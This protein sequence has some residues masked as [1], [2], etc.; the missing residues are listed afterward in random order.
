MF[1]RYTAQQIVAAE[2]ARQVSYFQEAV[3]PEAKLEEE[4]KKLLEHMEAIR[5]EKSDGRACFL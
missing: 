4:E 3:D 5:E 2:V 1:P